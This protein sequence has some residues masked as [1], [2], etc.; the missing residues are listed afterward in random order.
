MVKDEDNKVINLLKKESL[1]GYLEGNLFKVFEY[2]T[3]KI[4]F[5][6]SSEEKYLV[7]NSI[8]L[9]QPLSKYENNLASHCLY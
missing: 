5:W 3:P 8:D 7:N 1:E 4:I 2:N 6:R 9:E